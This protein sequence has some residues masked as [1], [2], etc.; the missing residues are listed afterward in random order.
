MQG[1]RM[2]R[3]R[4][5][6]SDCYKSLGDDGYKAAFPDDYEAERRA[7]LAVT[8]GKMNENR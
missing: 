7:L 6:C 3:S 5:V 4:V 1:F 8:T 2:V